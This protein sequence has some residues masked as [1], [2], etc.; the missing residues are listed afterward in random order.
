MN[1]FITISCSLVSGLLGAVLS[2][3]YSKKMEI[4]RTKIELL[5]KIVGKMTQLTEQYKGEIDLPV[6]LNQVYIVFNNSANV[7]EELLKFKADNKT[8]TYVSLIRNMCKDVGL[9]IEVFSDSFIT[10]PFC[11]KN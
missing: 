1:L 2:M 11:W 10:K 3:I 4:K 7:I 6:Y 8:D 9:S 5:T